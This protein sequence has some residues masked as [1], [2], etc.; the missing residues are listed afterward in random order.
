[1]WLK[2]FPF[3]HIWSSAFDFRSAQLYNETESGRK[4]IGTLDRGIILRSYSVI[5]KY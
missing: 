5:V 4:K 2:M 1:M 3:L